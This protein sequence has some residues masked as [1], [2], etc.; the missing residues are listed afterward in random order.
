MVTI[1]RDEG[2]AGVGDDGDMGDAVRP[3]KSAQRAM[4]ERG[5]RA[6][7]GL[8]ETAAKA[9]GLPDSCFDLNMLADIPSLPPGLDLKEEYGWLHATGTSTWAT[10]GSDDS[11]FIEKQIDI[12]VSTRWPTNI[13]LTDRDL[14]YC[15][16]F[17]CADNHIAVLVLAWAYILSARWAELVSG[18]VLEYNN[19]NSQIVDS[20]VSEPVII[21]NTGKINGGAARWWTAVL[22]K[23][24]W[25]A[26]I[27]SDETRFKSPWSIALKS[28]VR[29]R[30]SH[31]GETLVQPKA[32]SSVDALGYI[33]EYCNSHGVTDQCYAALSVALLL[34]KLSSRGRNVPLPI[35]KLNREAYVSGLKGR[36]SHEQLYELK[37]LD[38]LLVLSCNIKGI[39]GLLSSIFYDPKVACNF[40]SPWLQAIVATLKHAGDTQI[41][42]VMAARLPHL[43]FIWL[44]AIVTGFH[45]DII[46]DGRFGL[47]PIEPHSAMWTGTIQS[48]IQEPLSKPLVTDGYISRAN[49]CR[50][51]YI[52]QDEFH[53]RC[54]VSPWHP[55]GQTALEDTKPSVRANVEKV[56]GGLVYAKWRWASKEGSLTHQVPRGS[57]MPGFRELPEAPDMPVSYEEFGDKDVVSENATRMIFQWLRFEGYPA[58]ERPIYAH[59]WFDVDNSG[60][61]DHFQAI[62]RAERLRRRELGQQI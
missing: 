52:I 20:D 29:F 35:P 44:G 56:T 45:N 59:D 17:G 49:E 14:D 62:Q 8:V 43:A 25:E 19:N 10:D 41:I 3:A 4:F 55:F 58:S 18:A 27:P 46:K 13:I 7:S 42:H 30:L 16:W 36:A 38:K 61:D 11:V 47:I 5:F 28:P 15:S 50:L 31:Q 60:E 2:E 48:F 23:D 57:L 39:C 40:A 22:S 9:T 53:E 1:S 34:P 33:K 21:V 54:P 26:Y 12:D 24:G 51:L 32:I 37:C 6:W